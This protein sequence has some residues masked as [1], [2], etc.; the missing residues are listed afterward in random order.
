[1]LSPCDITHTSPDSD[2]TT[3]I[4][5]KRGV[6]RTMIFWMCVC[7]CVKHISGRGGGLNPDLL[8]VSLKGRGQKTWKKF[9]LA[10]KG[11][12]KEGGYIG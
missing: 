10:T 5:R 9:I 8:D 6:P 12:V 11:G 4:E 3:I 7:V 2:I 1:M